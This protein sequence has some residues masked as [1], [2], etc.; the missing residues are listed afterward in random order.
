MAQTQSPT[1]ARC[2]RC[3]ADLIF[4][5]DGRTG[6]AWAACEEVGTCDYQRAVESL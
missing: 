3:G 2:P 4:Y 5:L 1:E 6:D